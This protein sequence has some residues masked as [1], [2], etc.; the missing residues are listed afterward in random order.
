MINETGLVRIQNFEDSITVSGE[1]RGNPV[2]I[3][4]SKDFTLNSDDWF[5]SGRDPRQLVN[6]D[7]LRA[8]VYSEAGTAASKTYHNLG[9]ELVDGVDLQA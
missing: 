9:D 6:F 8:L 2:E 5:H 4:A 1:I 7:T 3:L